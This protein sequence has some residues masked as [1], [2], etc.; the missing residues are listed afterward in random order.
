M[1]LR[2]VSNPT[3]YIAC[4]LAAGEAQDRM[5]LARRPMSV[6]SFPAGFGRQDAYAVPCAADFD[7]TAREVGMWGRLRADGLS[8]QD[9]ADV[10]KAARL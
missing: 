8:P 1:T 4:V 6:T 10:V 3:P 2:S 7:L 5:N 9:A